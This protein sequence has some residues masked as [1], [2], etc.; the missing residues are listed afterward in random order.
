MTLTPSKSFQVP[1]REAIADNTGLVSQIWSWFFKG[2]WERL[3]PLG[4]EQSFQ[5]ANNIASPTEVT[6]LVFNSDGVSQAVVEYLVQRVTTGTGAHELI[7]SGIFIVCYRPTT[8]GWSI[9]LVQ[10][11]KPDDSGVDFTVTSSGQVQYTSSNIPGT[12]SIST[13][14]WRSRTIGGKNYQYSKMGR[15]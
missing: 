12:P 3:Y 10:I 4:I 5:L 7:E 8:V 2:T 11:N 14:Y 6:G 13:V 9:V 15:K 1:I